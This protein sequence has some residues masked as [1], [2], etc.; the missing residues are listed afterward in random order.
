MPVHVKAIATRQKR[1]AEFRGSLLGCHVD[2]EHY[3]L[4]GVTHC[5]KAAILAR[6]R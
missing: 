1:L 6:T 2:A 4:A 3:G 5:R